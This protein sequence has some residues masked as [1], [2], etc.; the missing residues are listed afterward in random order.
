MP[1]IFDYIKW[2]GDLSF[3]QDKFNN[4]DNLILSRFSYFPLDRVFE[5][6]SDKDKITIREA[7]LKLVTYG[8]KEEE[9]L[10]KEDNDL[11]PALAFSERFGN[12]EITKYVNKIDTKQEKQ[13]S[14][15]TIF[16]PDNTIYVSFRGTDNTIVGWKEDFNISL[17]IDIPSQ[18]EA[19]KYL[20]EMYD[21]T[22][23]NIR[24]G[25]H[26]KGG[27]LAMYA[28]I[29]CN[30]KVKKHIV[31]VY[32]NDGP[33]LNMNI[34][35]SAEYKQMLNKINS[36]IPQTSII[37]KLMYHEEKFNIIKSTQKGVMQHDLYSWQVDGK[38]FVYL[39]EVTNES[40]FIDAVIKE[41]TTKFTPEQRSEFINIIYEIIKKTNSDTLYEMSKNRFKT[42][43]NIIKAYH[44]TNKKSKQI[45]SQTFGELFGITKNNVFKNINERL[46]K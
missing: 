12:L 11:F 13:F 26:S 9:I 17:D 28:S 43:G 44:K 18:K 30:Q 27:N 25:G 4:V 21:I 40:E 31:E 14:A 7:Y 19:V 23:R 36:F 34:V 33:G 10:Q 5:D 32:N 41:W 16:I 22:K 24:V 1:N 39:K 20:E 8:I 29:M 37:G 15:V 6:Y 2:R 38:D 46:K 35:E 3:S 42:M 45:I